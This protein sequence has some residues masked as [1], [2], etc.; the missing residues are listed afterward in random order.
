V[1][2]EIGAGDCHLTCS[3][4][5][6]V[7]FVYAVDVSDEIASAKER[8]SNFAL[9]LSDGIHIDVPAGSVDVA[10]SHQ[11]MEHLHPEDAAAQLR[12][13]Y[14]ALRPG[15]V[16]ICT[17]P[18]RFSGPHDIS[19]YFTSQ[20]AGFHLKEYCYGELREL[21]RAC[22]FSQSHAWVGLKG[23]FAPLPNAAALAS[24]M[25]VEWMP[26]RLRKNVARLPLLR[27]LF[28]SVTIVG[29]K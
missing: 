24:E 5:A 25:A 27:A 23:A 14:A 4:A 13:I 28:D 29:R 2:L 6:E 17:T 9:I 21:F 20:A 11:L 12:Q 18:H 7:Q 15:G 8:P 16:Y 26:H 1:Y 22:G 19:K 3:V 10:Y